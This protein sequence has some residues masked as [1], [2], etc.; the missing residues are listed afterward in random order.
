MRAEALKGHLDALL[1]AALESKPAHGFAVM[2][3][4][5]RRTGAARWTWKVAPS[6]PAL[7]RLERAA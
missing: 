4:P 3:E 5:R 2:A 1:P 6:Y 7:R